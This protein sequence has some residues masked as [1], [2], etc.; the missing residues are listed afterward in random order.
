[1]MEENQAVRMELRNL[2]AKMETNLCVEMEVFLSV[3]MEETLLVH[4]VQ[5]ETDQSVEMERPDHLVLMELNL[6]NL[7]VRM[8]TCQSVQMEQLQGNLAED[9]VKME[10][11]HFVLME[12]ALYVLM[13]HRLPHVQM[14]LVLS[15]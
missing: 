6:V 3:L 1:M 5:M 14:E 9:S 12:T 11:N 10:P 13:A 2:L 4:H 8:E 15:A 7:I